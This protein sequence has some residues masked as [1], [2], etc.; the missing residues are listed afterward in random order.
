MTLSTSVFG[1]LKNRTTAFTIVELL[2]VIGIISVLAVALLVTLNPAEA[3]R[4]SRDAKRVK[5]ANTIQAIIEQHL[6]DG[7]TL[8]SACQTS[9]TCTSLT[10]AVAGAGAANT[11]NC[12]VNTNWLRTDLC[13]YA[14]TIPSDP[15]NATGRACQGVTG[16]CALVYYLTTNASNDYEIGVRQEAS[17]NA[18]KL[19][20]DGGGDDGLLE[21]VSREDL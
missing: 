8:P 19:T 9:G 10:L 20:S 11:Q 7:G 6:N 4:R 21:I 13:L 16:S 3:Q 15:V 12:S 5:D 18:G 17:S 1:S 14:K 2:V